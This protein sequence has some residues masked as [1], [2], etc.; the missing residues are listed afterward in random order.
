[1]FFT[2]LLLSIVLIV[3]NYNK[4]VKNNKDIKSFMVIIS[5]HITAIIY[6]FFVDSLNDYSLNKIFKYIVEFLMPWYVKYMQ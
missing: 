2:I 1:M 3:Y 5:M 4:L 6:A